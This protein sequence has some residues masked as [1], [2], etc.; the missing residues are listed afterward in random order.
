MWGRMQT[1]RS[2]SRRDILF[3]P[4]RSK[5]RCRLKVADQCLSLSGVACRA[6]EDSC[7]VGAIR[8]Q[9]R[10]GCVDQISVEATTCTGCGDCLLVC[11][12]TALSLE[13][14]RPHG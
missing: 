11:P 5:N 6:C 7:T 14:T 10:L 8:F 13:G 3:G 1:E 12:V 2:I 4:A 9:P